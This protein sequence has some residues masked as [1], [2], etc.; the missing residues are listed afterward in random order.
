MFQAMRWIQILY[1]LSSVLYFRL[2]K[3][4]RVYL[5]RVLFKTSIGATLKIH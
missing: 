2:K 1:T 3:P 4:Y 5:A